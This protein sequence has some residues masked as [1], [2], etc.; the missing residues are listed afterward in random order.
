MK[1]EPIIV[2]KDKGLL[3]VL[4]E[5]GEETKCAWIFLHRNAVDELISTADDHSPRVHSGIHILCWNET[6]VSS[7]KLMWIELHPNKV[8][9]EV[10]LI[11][12]DDI[13]F[14]WPADDP[15][16]LLFLKMDE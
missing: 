1:K 15:D 4:A 13:A 12:A 14:N 11:D 3:D 16:D 5:M 7:K 2:P 8:W 6:D 9:L 10:R